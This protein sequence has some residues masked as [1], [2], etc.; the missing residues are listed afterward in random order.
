MII[1]SEYIYYNIS[2]DIINVIVKT[3]IDEHNKKHGHDDFFKM[4][5]KGNIEVFDLIKS[6][7]EIITVAARNV[8]HKAQ[9]TIVASKEKRKIKLME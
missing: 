3:T 9:R 2:I 6:K 7:T 5:K 1:T 8:M 4:T